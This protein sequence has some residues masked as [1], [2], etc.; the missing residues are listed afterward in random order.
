MSGGQSA[1]VALAR[2]V[3]DFPEVAGEGTKV[4]LLDNPFSS[5]DPRVGSNIFKNLLG[6][7]GLIRKAA[8]V[9]TIDETSLRFYLDSL[10][11]SGS[12][13]SVSLKTHMMERGVLSETEQGAYPSTAAVMELPTAR[14]TVEAPLPWESPFAPPPPEET[15]TFAEQAYSGVVGKQTY[16]WYSKHVGYGVLLLMGLMI[17]TMHTSGIGSD[18]WSVTITVCFCFLYLLFRIAH[19]TAM[20]PED[21]AK[22]LSPVVSHTGPPELKNSKALEK[23]SLGSVEAHTHGQHAS[24]FEVERKRRKPTVQDALEPGDESYSLIELSNPITL[25]STFQSKNEKDEVNMSA[26]ATFIL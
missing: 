12:R 17:I 10:E 24:F 23:A 3:Y 1:R 25:L 6:P 21:K 19:W 26:L 7:D 15:A 11:A 5:T 13:L 4:F 9:L 14:R 18:F 22:P 20:A 2:A 8:V 16:W